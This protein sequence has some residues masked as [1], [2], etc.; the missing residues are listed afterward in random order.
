[1]AAYGSQ[2]SYLLAGEESTFNTPVSVNKSLGFIS[3]ASIDANNNI[4]D[5]R[6]IGSREAEVLLGGQFEVNMTVDG[7]FNS[8]A[9]MEMFFGQSTDTETTGD[10]KHTFIDDDGS[11]TVANTILSYT[12]QPNFNSSSDVTLTLGG[13]KVNTLDLSMELGGVAEY[14]SEIFATDVDTGTTA[15][16]QVSTT[17][18]PLTFAQASISTG[19]E[20]SESALSEVQSFNISFNNTLERVG[21]I[22]SRLTQE[23]VVGN[24]E[25]TGDFTM[26]FQN[27]DEF[28]RF[29][30]GSSASTSTPTDTGLIYTANNGVT[31]GSGRIEFYVKGADV[32]YESTNVAIS[33]EGTIEASFNFKIGTLR[34]VFFVDAVDTY[35]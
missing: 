30:G 1:M 34:D 17:T 32:Q 26:K 21:G 14:S 23:M 25:V 22:G 19:D 27:K 28:E 3:N 5:V 8:G 13:C 33:T 4:I 2:Q 15:G 11:E 24:L 18:T 12:I 35:F 20:E 31:L 16:T 10:Y 7:T 29:L 6:S 9:L